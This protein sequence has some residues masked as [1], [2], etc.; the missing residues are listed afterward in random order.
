MAPAYLYEQQSATI[1]DPVDL[2]LDHKAPSC[3]LV[4]CRPTRPTQKENLEFYSCLEPVGITS[5]LTVSFADHVDI[6]C[7]SAH[8]HIQDICKDL[9]CFQLSQSNL[10]L[11][12]F[13]LEFLIGIANRG[14]HKI[15][16]V[17]ISSARTI[18]RTHKNKSVAAILHSLQWLSIEQ[19][20]L[21]FTNHCIQI[22]RHIFAPR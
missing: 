15:Q 12:W 7:K 13:L 5:D 9:A 22:S 18:I 10:Q 3:M 1:T 19:S 11:L 17:Q 14:L 21:Q 20:V 16:M 4:R 8:Y 6:I 2:R